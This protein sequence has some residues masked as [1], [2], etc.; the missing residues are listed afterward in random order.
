MTR[1]R[2]PFSGW[3]EGKAFLFQSIPRILAGK[4]VDNEKK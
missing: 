1:L 3:S 4:G 2:T